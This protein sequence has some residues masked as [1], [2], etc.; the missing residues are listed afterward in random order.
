MTKKL[1]TVKPKMTKRKSRKAVQT[2]VAIQTSKTMSEASIKLGISR[3]T[4][5]DRIKAYDL[6]PIIQDMR[7][8]AE[9]TLIM[10]TP[11]IVE[12]R[13]AIATGEKKVSKQ[14]DT[15]Q[16][17]LLDRVGISKKDPQTAIGIQ[18]TDMSIEFIST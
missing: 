8:Q 11:A 18:S 3:S 14:Q 4:L 17:D 7:K 1:Q 13:V 12:D 15:A 10:S 16:K 6:M 9:T 5:Y 2:V